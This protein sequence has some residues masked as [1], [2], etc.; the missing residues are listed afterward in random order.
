MRRVLVLIAGAALGAVVIGAT[1]A[2]ADS[3]MTAATRD[4]AGQGVEVTTTGG[5]WT[6]T[7]VDMVGKPAQ[8]L[9]TIT[10]T[11]TGQRY[12]SGDHPQLGKSFESFQDPPPGSYR[13]QSRLHGGPVRA[14]DSV[15]LSIDTP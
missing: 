12:F 8:V 13:I 7:V 14:G 6:F 5:T 4:S 10:D 1:V 2:R 11:V 15:T 3:L 9:V